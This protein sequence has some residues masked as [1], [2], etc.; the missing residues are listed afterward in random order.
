MG[1]FVVGVSGASGM[2]L[3][4]RLI[5][6]LTQGG[7]SVEL[8][9]SKAALYTAS[10]ELGKEYATPEK[11][12]AKIENKKQVSIQPSQDTGCAIAS[13]SFLTDGMII[14]PCSMTT[15][16]AVAM[17]LG[18]NVL[19]RAA[20]VTLKERRQ[21]I[22]VPREAPFNQIHLENMLKLSR[23]G[24]TILPPIPAWYT[25]PKSLE[26]VENF[27]VGKILDVL[28][29]EHSLYPRWKSGSTTVD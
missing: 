17:G 26:D 11:F 25:E 18:D 4:L 28:K 15:L 19:R 1:R 2:V 13:G 16:A 21:L 23:M 9:M 12:I 14:V 6:A 22:I 10:L 7:H 27:I 8:T 20:D 29:I 3:A 5:D 24:A